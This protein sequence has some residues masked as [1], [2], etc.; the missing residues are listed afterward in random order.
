MIHGNVAFEKTVLQPPKTAE[1]G[2]GSFHNCGNLWHVYIRNSAT[3]MDM[4]SCSSK[5][6]K[7]TQSEREKTS[8]DNNDVENKQRAK[9]VQQKMCDKIYCF[10]TPCSHKLFTSFPSDDGSMRGSAFL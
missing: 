5:A 2:K 1:L 7:I 3:I 4:P 8:L 9:T 10:T 6:K